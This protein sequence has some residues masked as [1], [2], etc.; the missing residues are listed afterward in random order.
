MQNENKYQFLCIP[1]I[2][3]VI[4]KQ[5]IFSIFCKLNIGYIEKINEIPNKSKPDFKRIIIKIK[6]NESNDRAVF[7]WNRLL[8]GKDIKFVYS[9]PWY[10]KIV[11][12]QTRIL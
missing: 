10:W 1:Q 9:D 4:S 8:E 5:Y 11:L 7:I 2:R 6:K 3:S 12:A